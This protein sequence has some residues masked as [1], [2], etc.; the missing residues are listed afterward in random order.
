MKIRDIIQ[1]ERGRSRLK[2]HFSVC[3]RQEGHDED[4]NKGRVRVSSRMTFAKAI[5]RFT[6][7]IL[8]RGRIMVMGR[9]K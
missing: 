2:V 9:G 1:R 6:I 5:I 4:Y 7:T 3:V 8:V